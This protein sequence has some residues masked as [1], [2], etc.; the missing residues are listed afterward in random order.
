[1]KHHGHYTLMS[2]EELAENLEAGHDKGFIRRQLM[3]RI[4]KYR[5]DKRHIQKNKKAYYKTH[6]NLGDMAQGAPTNYKD[7]YGRIIKIGDTIFYNNLRWIANKFSKLECPA[8]KTESVHMSDIPPL[9]MEIINHKTTKVMNV[10]PDI[11]EIL[12]NDEAEQTNV[13]QNQMSEITD[14][15]ILDGVNIRGLS[16]T[17]LE[18][19]SE[20]ELINEVLERGIQF[21]FPKDDIGIENILDKIE[22]RFLV[23]ELKKR[24]FS[25]KLTKEFEL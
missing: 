19:V 6:I 24:G 4:R 25:G 1:M 5:N 2:P 21:M 10:A 8:G 22:D 18:K 9:D 17:I 20:N 23:Q 13:E 3:K 14:G 15:Q 7:K 16:Q 11:N 12:N